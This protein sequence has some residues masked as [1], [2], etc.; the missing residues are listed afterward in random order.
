M[1]MQT[2]AQKASLQPNRLLE[3]FS[4]S[5]AHICFN[6]WWNTSC[7]LWLEKRLVS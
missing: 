3:W 2:A 5:D 6:L 7:W 1:L 4:H